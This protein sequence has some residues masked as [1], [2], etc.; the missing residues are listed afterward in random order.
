MEKDMFAQKAN[1]FIEAIEFGAFHIISLSKD[2]ELYHYTSL[3]ALQN[4]LETGI[5]QA[6]EYHYLNDMDEFSFVDKLLIKTLRK[7]F[8]KDDKSKQLISAVKEYMKTIRNESEELE[9]SYYVM[10]FSVAKDNLILWTEFAN[11]GC[12]IGVNPYLLQKEDNPRIVYSGFVAYSIGEQ[13]ELIC[14]SIVNVFE[15]LCDKENLEISQL[16]S[17]LEEFNEHEIE[18]TAYLIARLTAYYGSAMKD[19]LYTAEMEYRL[20]FSGKNQKVKYRQKGNMLIPYI[21]I[22]LAIDNNFPALSSVTLAPL[23]KGKMQ[24]KS[25]E[26]FLSN[27][28]LEDKIVFESRLKLRY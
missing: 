27:L 19:E 6:T 18:V 20:V 3:T 9:E 1:E 12:N 7:I 5:F 2:E 8:G 22:P 21:E 11:Y 14:N 24:K 28:G 23:G 4:I 15:H 25:M 13:R 26:Q 10:S 16:I 17:C